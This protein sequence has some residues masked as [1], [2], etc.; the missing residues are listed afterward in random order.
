MPNPLHWTIKCVQTKY[1]C[2]FQV[3]SLFKAFHARRTS[4]IHDLKRKAKNE[5]SIHEEDKENEQ[6]VQVI[7]EGDEQA[8]NR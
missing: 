3:E 5:V 8:D 2:V 1:A 6:K 4:R 7:Q